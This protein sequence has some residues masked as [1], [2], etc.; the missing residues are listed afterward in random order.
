[1]PPFLLPSEFLVRGRVNVPERQAPHAVVGFGSE[2]KGLRERNVLLSF[3]LVH[4][5]AVVTLLVFMM[6]D[7][8]GVGGSPIERPPVKL[9]ATVDVVSRFR[10]PPIPLL[11]GGNP[12]GVTC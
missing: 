8:A 12:A 4:A 9:Q 5:I 3:R 10:N 7:T 2:S 1:M 6:F 11:T